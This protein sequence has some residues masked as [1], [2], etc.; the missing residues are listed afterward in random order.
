MPD[1]CEEVIQKIESLLQKYMS[2]GPS[3]AVYKLPT[4]Q[5]GAGWVLALRTPQRTDRRRPEI[6]QVVKDLVQTLPGKFHQYHLMYFNNLD[7]PLPS[8]L[9]P[10][11]QPPIDA[12]QISSR[13]DLDLR[14][15]SWLLLRQSR[16]RRR[17]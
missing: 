13:E 17:R 6:S 1:R 2:A 4:I 9:M 7:A 16:R 3:I 8:P 10:S 15:H 11:M 14:I 12:L 5:P